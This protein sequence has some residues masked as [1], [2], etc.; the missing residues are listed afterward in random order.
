MIKL[1]AFSDSHG[2]KDNLKRIGKIL[3]DYD[4]CLFLGDG[5]GDIASYENALNE[6]F[7]AV[8]GNCDF[9]SNRVTEILTKISGKKVFLTHGHRFRVKEGITTL[10]YQAEELGADIVFYGHTHIADIDKLN[11]IW[12]INPGS[13]SL[14][15][16]NKPSYAHVEIIDGE[17]EARIVYL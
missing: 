15:R 17:I 8:R 7:F 5:L 11:G 12:Y 10:S 9:I 6:K 13:I 4:F 3:N 2:Y 16:I 14:P 1:I